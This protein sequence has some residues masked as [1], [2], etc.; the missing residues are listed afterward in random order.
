MHMAIFP[1]WVYSFTERPALTYLQQAIPSPYQMPALE[2]LLDL[3]TAD[4]IQS[5]YHGTYKEDLQKDGN[6]FDCS[7]KRVR[8]YQQL[9]TTCREL[10]NVK[11]Y[12]STKRKPGQRSDYTLQPTEFARHPCKAAIVAAMN[13]LRK[14][15]EENLF[16]MA[17]QFPRRVVRSWRHEP[18][19]AELLILPV[20]VLDET[21]KV[22]ASG[23]L[24]DFMVLH[25]LLYFKEAN[26]I[27]APV[28]GWE[29][30]WLFL[31]GDGLSLDRIFQFFDDVM[32]I[33]DAKTMSFCNAYR[34]AMAITQVL[35]RIV[36]INGDLHVRFHML[37]SVYRLFYG[38]FLQCFQHRLKWKRLDAQDVSHSYRLAHRLAVIVFEELDRLMVDIFINRA[39][40]FGKIERIL[41]SQGPDGLAI[42]VANDYVAYLHRQVRETKDWLHRYLCNY[43]VVMRKYLAFCKA[44]QEGDAVTMEAVVVDYLPV[45][46]ATKKHKSFATQLRLIEMYYHRIPISILQLI[47][48]NRT[49]LQKKG[50]PYTFQKESA[51]DQIME[52]LMP[53]FKGMNHNGTEASFVR[54]SK[55]LTA[56]Q[57]AKHFVEFYTRT[58]A[59][60]EYKYN[61][62]SLENSF[63]IDTP[64]TETGPLADPGQRNKTTTRPS[65]RLNRVL[66][67]EILTLAKCHDVRENLNIV[68]DKD[69]FWRAL[70]ATTME[71]HKRV[72]RNGEG[73]I[74]N[75]AVDKYV[76][77]KVDAMMRNMRKSKRCKEDEDKGPDEEEGSK[78]AAEEGDTTDENSEIDLAEVMDD[79]GS[80]IIQELTC[81]SDDESV[82]VEV[83]K[84]A[85]CY[86]K[87]EETVV[88]TTVTMEDTDATSNMEH[89]EVRDERD[90]DEVQETQ[91]D[92]MEAEADEIPNEDDDND[93]ND[94]G[95]DGAPETDNSVDKKD[96]PKETLR[97]KSS[98]KGMKVVEMN[99]M[100][101]TDFIAGAV[102]R[103]GEKQVVTSLQ[104][105]AA[106]KERDHHFLRYK[107]Y[108]RLEGMEEDQSN[109]E[110]TENTRETTGVAHHLDR[111]MDMLASYKEDMET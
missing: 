87:D 24:L 37:D 8:V 10:W 25:G 48:L 99:R 33:T 38:G 89:D 29:K 23:I 4:V 44:E 62:R 104:W 69:R 80:S 67:T 57:R 73:R 70:D 72:R 54:V 111:C 88:D 84:D 98:I 1:D 20:S 19:P 76:P 55:M 95:S 74:E 106:R 63:D 21:T 82:F 64:T 18:A 34:Q 105:D 101:T 59:D 42:F 13:G 14:N 92:D 66:V 110:W 81:F 27:Y 30:K 22:G 6:P 107:L 26:Q 60:A 50:S 35:H 61:E 28:D 11:R 41:K 46:Y 2:Q 16:E 96:S 100:A 51:L 97:E 17:R 56:C 49:K 75:D 7:G 47:R 58:R 5:I 3:Q 103:M 83:E 52:R 94:E 108:H 79:D 78:N 90:E 9:N 68:I 39:M 43:L 15:R 31:V 45:L 86:Y 91:V 85:P 40:T 102:E 32:A 93:D 109:V 36:P 12:L 77:V 71:V 65:S 53:F